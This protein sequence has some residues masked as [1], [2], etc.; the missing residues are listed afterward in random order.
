M[1]KKNYIVLL[2]GS[3]GKRGDII[4][5]DLG[6]DGLSERQATMLAEYEKPVVK[7]DESAQ[8]KELTKKVAALEL[9]NKELTEAN[10]AL[11]KTK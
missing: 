5:L 4:E 7:S 3:Y 1:A 2:T 10:S 8:V 11:T 6:K 9:A